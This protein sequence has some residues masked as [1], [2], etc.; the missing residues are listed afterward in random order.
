MY[1]QKFILIFAVIICTN[2]LAVHAQA[3]TL[4]PV[5]RAQVLQQLQVLMAQVAKLQEQLHTLQEKAPVLTHSQDHLYPTTFFTDDYES[6]YRV[7]DTALL[8]R[9]TSAV[10]P[11]DEALFNTFV[12]M[13]GESFINDFIAEFRVFSDMDSELGGFVEQKKDG[14]WILGINRFDDNLLVTHD[15]EVVT[16]LLLHEYAHIVFFENSK[17]TEDFIDEF[18]NTRLMQTHFEDVA[19]ITNFTVH[20]AE[21]TDFYDLHPKLFVS[22]YAASSPD[23]DI[24]ESFTFFVKNEKPLD[25]LVR[26]EKVRFF[27]Q[28]PELVQMR[29]NLRAS[30]LITLI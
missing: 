14:Y 13:T 21:T 8:P 30:G 1:L 23:E 28:Y 27:Y 18:W 25:S 24:V 11:G 22:E 5:V 26:D 7:S 10:R 29:N 16:D 6:A 3:P 4:T 19:E 20:L 17:F 9:I 15:D 2:V 12:D